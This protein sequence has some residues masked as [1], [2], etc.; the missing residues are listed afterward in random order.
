[1][2]KK[3]TVK[4]FDFKDA[5]SDELAD[6]FSDRAMELLNSGDEALLQEHF[7]SLMMVQRAIERADDKAAEWEAQQN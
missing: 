2:G 7:H 6:I 4:Q 1:M 5:L 3:K